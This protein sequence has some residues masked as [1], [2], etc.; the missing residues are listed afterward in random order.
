MKTVNAQPLQAR[1]LALEER[2]DQLVQGPIDVEEG[3]DGGSENEYVNGGVEV[4]EA[5]VRSGPVSASRTSEL[6]VAFEGEVY[7]FPAV[8]PEKV[9]SLWWY[10][11]SLGLCLVLGKRKRNSCGEQDFVALFCFFLSFIFFLIY[12]IFM[13]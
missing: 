2:E 4:V 12:F 6:T 1:P 3:D 13:F 8:T 9:R 5:R 7:V 11:L 10:Y